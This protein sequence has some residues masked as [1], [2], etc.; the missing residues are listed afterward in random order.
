MMAFPTFELSAERGSRDDLP[1]TCAHCGAEVYERLY[2][3]DDCFAIY[4]GK[5]PKCGA[6]NVL[7]PTGS[8]TMR[9]YGSTGMHLCLPTPMETKLNGYGDVPTREP[10][11]ESERAWEAEQAAKWDAGEIEEQSWITE[12]PEPEKDVDALAPDS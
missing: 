11:S 9:G 12:T 6:L 5:C 1:G 3:L 8:Q 10:R 4:A 7:D 2:R